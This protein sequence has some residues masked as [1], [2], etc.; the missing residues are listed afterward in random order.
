MKS[1][2]LSISPNSIKK[3]FYDF[4]HRFHVVIFVV[5]ALGGLALSVFVLNTI[6]MSSSNTNHIPIEGISSGFDQDTINKI[7]E[8]KTRDQSDNPLTLP[9]GRNNPFVE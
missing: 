8:L 2:K 5:V 9:P 4:M 3:G 7:E 6:I 1:F